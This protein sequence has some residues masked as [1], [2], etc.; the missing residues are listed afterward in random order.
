MQ[1]AA[2]RLAGAAAVDVSRCCN[3]LHVKHAA[4]ATRVAGNAT[5]LAGATCISNLAPSM[6]AATAACSLSGQ[7]RG[8][9]SAAIANQ[10]KQQ[11]QYNRL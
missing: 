8:I 10:G 9:S 4:L 6:T 7:H 3:S 11:V 5:D 2:R 1:Q